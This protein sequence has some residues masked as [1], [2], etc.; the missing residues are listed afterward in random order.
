M[1][2]GELNPIN[3]SHQFTT[4]DIYGR[5]SKK[6]PT[7]RSYFTSETKANDQTGANSLQYQSV[8]ESGDRI[9]LESNASVFITF[10]RQ[11]VSAE[12]STTSGGDGQGQ[13]DSKAIL[14][15]EVEQNNTR[16]YVAGT[17]AYSFE[18][19]G[20]PSAGA[21]DPGTGGIV[22]RRWI[23]WQWCIDDLSP[24]WYQISVVVNPKVEEGFAGP[25]SFTCEVF[26]T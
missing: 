25:G 16:E 15:F 12:N 24:G 11:F 1:Q 2:R 8:R 7:E 3:N 21:F 9:Y 22:A 17:R 14:K 5:G 23:G 19:T 6:I 13:W 20:A 26:Y 10:G 18:E 4:G